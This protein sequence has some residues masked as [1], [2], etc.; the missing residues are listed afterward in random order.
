MNALA[1]IEPLPPLDLSRSLKTLSWPAWLQHSANGLTVGS[2]TVTRADG[3]TG[4]LIVPTIVR[5]LA[6]SPQARGAIEARLADLR[7]ARDA[8]DIDFAMAKVAELLLSFAGQAMNEAGAKAR[9]RGYITALED[10]P[11]W[12]I[13]EACRR[14]LR[15]EA[16]ESQNYN[17]APSP[18]VLRKIAES[19]VA[20]VDHQAT[21]L[22]RL[23]TAKVVDDPEEFTEEHCAD[24]RVRLDKLFKDVAKPKEMPK[25]EI[26][27]PTDEALRAHYSPPAEEDAA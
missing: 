8:V 16:G 14:W 26:A 1:K 24:M 17:F 21:V 5:S 9:A 13:A 15:G 6:P 4:K 18:P 19:V 7:A 10:L 2:E 25:R 3:V 11:A 22:E 27:G 20:V 12:A 23:L